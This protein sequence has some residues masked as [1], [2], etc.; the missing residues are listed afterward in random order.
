Q[1]VQPSISGRHCEVRVQGGELLVRDLLSTNGTFAGGRQISEAVLKPGDIL[2]LGDVEL[3]FETASAPEPPGTS[4]ISKS[5]MMQTAPKKTEPAPAPVEKKTSPSPPPP[6]PTAGKEIQKLFQVL[7]VDDSMAFLELFGGLCEEFSQ[8]TWHIHKVTSADSALALMRNVDMDLV[9]LDITM[10][11][12]DG[13]QLLGLINRRHPGLKIAVMTGSATEAKRADALANGAEL[14][15]E[16]PVTAEGMRA[17]FNMLQDLVLWSREGFT[18]ALRQVNLQEVI[19]VQCNGRHS[20]ILE[21][22]TPQL[23]GQ[24]YIEA[25]AVTHST[26]GNLTGRPAFYRLLS[27]RGGD[28]AVKPFQAPPQRTI[29]TPWEYLLMDAALA[30]DEESLSSKQVAAPQPTPLPAHEDGT[31]HV[32]VGD[33]LVTLP[34]PDPKLKPAG[35]K[36]DGTKT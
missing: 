8:Q 12:L 5:L 2:R 30:I 18:G 10:P 26:V 14:F 35:S 22:R 25:G 11:M 6:V 36:S 17:V 9:L 16:K 27:L 4:F 28:F 1:V 7:F 24:I 15:L 3:R 23:R 34:P 20:T 33:Y 13:L 31:T 29:N 32:A 21:I 19:Q